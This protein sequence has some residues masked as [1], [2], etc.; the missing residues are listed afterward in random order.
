MREFSI[1]R[2][3]EAD[4]GVL[5]LI[6]EEADRLYES[7]PGFAAMA[8]EPN[9][10][11]DGY[12]ALPKST[13]V[14]LA[15]TIQPVGFI[16]SF[17]MDDLAYIG[18]LSVVPEAARRGIGKALVEIVATTAKAE[19]KRGVVLTTYRDVA[20]NGSF[21]A[22]L[23]FLELAAPVMGPALL[24]HAGADAAR[25]SRFSERAVMGRFF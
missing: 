9:L 7:L 5:P 14:W 6:E 11:P 22:K 19:G 20:W 8:E 10:S 24:A 13:K 16:Y 23:G 2:I 3:K 15:E 25:W 12:R 18:Q 21:Y 4:F 17:D 1:R